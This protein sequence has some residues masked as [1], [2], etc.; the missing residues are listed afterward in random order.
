MSW[1]RWLRW[2]LIAA[3]VGVI[4]YVVV[5]ALYQSEDSGLMA[6]GDPST[7]Q[8]ERAKTLWDWMDLL[9]VPVMLAGGAIWFNNQARQRDEANKEIRYKEDMLQKYFDDMIAL[10]DQQGQNAPQLPGS[11][12]SLRTIVVLRRLD[13]DRIQEVLEFLRQIGWLTGDNAVLKGAK[14]IEIDLSGADL[15]FADLSEAVLQGANL[16]GADLSA[17]ELSGVEFGL[18]DLTEANLNDAT[19]VDADFSRADLRGAVL[20]LADLSEAGLREA[21]LRGANLTNSILSGAVGLDEADFDANTILPDGS[22]WS[23][24]TDLMRFTEPIG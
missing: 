6:F 8:Y 14:L 3:V 7:A 13:H 2:L 11:V 15:H 10:L 17:A 23:R 24:D 12:A 9:I 18:A 19:L 1:F 20:E 5:G 22:R 16:S 4:V 21:D